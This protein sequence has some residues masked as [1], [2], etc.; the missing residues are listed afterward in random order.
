MDRHGGEIEA[1]VGLG[2]ERGGELGGQPLDCLAVGGPSGHGH[3]SGR[4]GHSTI[5]AI[6]AQHTAQGAAE[7]EAVAADLAP[8]EEAVAVAVHPQA[9]RLQPPQPVVADSSPYGLTP[10]L[11]TMAG[12][13]LSLDPGLPARL[14]GL[15]QRRC[16][17][18]PG[19]HHDNQTCP[20]HFFH[21]ASSSSLDG[22]RPRRVTFPGMDPLIADIRRRRLAARRISVLTGAGVSAASGVPTFR[23]A[24][25][26]WRDRQAQQLATRE[27]FEEEPALVWEW[28]A[29]RRQ[30]IAGCQPNAAHQ[31]IAR[32][33]ENPGFT[34]ITQNVDGLHERA[35][36][37]NVVRYHGSIWTLR[38][39]ARCGAADWDDLSVPLPTV[40]PRCPAC[41][42]LARPGVVWFGEAIPPDALRAAEQAT[43][44]ELFVSIGTSSVVYPAAGLIAEA[45]R[46]GAFTVE[47]NPEP[48]GAGVDAAIALPAESVLPDL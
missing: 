44:C 36:T 26:L 5:L 32:W 48:T 25:G 40:P 38:C 45:K 7:R 4:I 23:G 2:L 11:E 27:A 47:I 6:P 33:S 31:A 14:V 34:L 18:H 43:G 22:S 10:F 35:G 46:R 24:G 8:R 41:G 42:G 19:A 39:W 30:V 3:V 17:E 28:Y 13:L 20:D 29:W 21:A 15:R 37:R 16:P 9:A 12:P 1:D